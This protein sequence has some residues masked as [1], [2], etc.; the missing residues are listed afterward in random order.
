MNSDA[1]Q[2][3]PRL[4]SASPPPVP[5]DRP[6]EGP[7]R[8]AP[9]APRF[10]TP[11]T[12]RDWILRALILV[13]IAGSVALVWW[14][15]QR[16]V[17]VQQQAREA[18]ALLARLANEVRTMETK[19]PQ[20][21][22]DRIRADHR[23]AQGLLFGG[24]NAVAPWFESLQEDLIPL[25]LEGRASFGVPKAAQAAGQGLAIVPATVSVDL[26]PAADIT[27]VATPY[28]RLL[29]FVDLLGRQAKRVDLLDLQ[30][31]GG[32]NSVAKASAT[33]ELWAGTEGRQ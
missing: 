18:N 21:V 6:G 11:L 12:V 17:P 15:Y 1:P 3:P 14:S 8:P 28:V 20:E 22:I 24:E 30:V 33:L 32:S 16:L 4:A 13:V 26:K 31:S 7:P 27:S 10:K 5:E 19:Y 9:P 29:R 2:V 25:A 23:A